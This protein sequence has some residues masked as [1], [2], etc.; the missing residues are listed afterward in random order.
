MLVH[1]WGLAEGTTAADYEADT[2]GSAV[3]GAVSHS[4]ARKP[5]TR[6]RGSRGITETIVR[7]TA[8]Q[9]HQGA[10]GINA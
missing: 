7:A 10:H 6:P 9:T 1:D 4:G 3:V 8:L 5:C 2:A